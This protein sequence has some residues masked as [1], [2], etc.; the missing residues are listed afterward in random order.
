MYRAD[1]VQLN[2]RAVYTGREND[3]QIMRA[4]NTCVC[5]CVIGID[6]GYPERN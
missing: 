1:L 6:C 4:R 3:E 2:T 5:V